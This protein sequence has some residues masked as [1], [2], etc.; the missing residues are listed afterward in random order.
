M[1][2]SPC[3]TSSTLPQDKEDAAEQDSN[4]KQKQAFDPGISDGNIY[5]MVQDII[6][7]FYFK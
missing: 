6:V 7:P 4:Q 5:N 1:V 2:I 3:C